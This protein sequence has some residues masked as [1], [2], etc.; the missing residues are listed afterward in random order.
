MYYEC[1][2][3]G[4]IISEDKIIDHGMELGHRLLECPHCGEW[5]SLITADTCPVC[6]EP[7]KDSQELCEECTDIIA[8]GLNDIQQKLDCDYEQLQEAIDVYWTW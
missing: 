6:G 1:T 8:R 3:C 2:G 5:D 7:V 4:E